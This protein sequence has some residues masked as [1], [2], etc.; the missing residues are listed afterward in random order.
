MTKDVM[1][2]T[3]LH[4]STVMRINASVNKDIVSEEKVGRKRKLAIDEENTIIDFYLKEAYYFNFKHLN[5]C[6]LIYPILL[7]KDYLEKEIYLALYQE[8][9]RKKVI[10]KLRQ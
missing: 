7:L 6:G 9:T 3:N 1:K 10:I 4:K 2:I 8:H 5:K